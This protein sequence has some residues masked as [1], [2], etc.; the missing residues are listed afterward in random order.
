MLNSARYGVERARLARAGRPG[1]MA[2]FRLDYAR[3]R[4]EDALVERE[5]AE[6]AEIAANDN[7]RL[8]VGEPTA[9]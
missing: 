9:A 6:A 5:R 8:A 3:A 4:Y 2:D 1:R 7:G